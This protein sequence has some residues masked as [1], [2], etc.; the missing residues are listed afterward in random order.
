MEAIINEESSLQEIE[1]TYF[2]ITRSAL[3]FSLNLAHFNVT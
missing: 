2:F 1:L 3:I